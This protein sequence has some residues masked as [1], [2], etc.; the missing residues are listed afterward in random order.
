MEKVNIIIGRFQPFT[1]GHLKCIKEVYEE[2]GCRTIIL[3]IDGK[4][5]ERSPLPKYVLD[6]MFTIL[7]KEYVN[8][9]ADVIYVKNA[10]IVIN[11]ELVRNKYYEPVSWVCGTDRYAP[12]KKM[13]DNYSIKANLMPYFKVF[14]VNRSDD[15][16]SATSV[17][18][19]LKM[20]NYGDYKQNMPECLYGM[21]N[22][23]KKIF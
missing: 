1:L 12:Y 23:F 3:V 14:C 5:S 10:D 13:V 7:K 20:G 2:T 21:Y 9:I 17:R 19:A 8:Y 18:N 22:F 4:T 15:A 11:A 16:I 6:K